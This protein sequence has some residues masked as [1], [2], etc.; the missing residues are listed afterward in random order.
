[1][2]SRIDTALLG[3]RVECKT[4]ILLVAFTLMSPTLEISFILPEEGSL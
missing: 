2:V 3:E 1:M 4:H